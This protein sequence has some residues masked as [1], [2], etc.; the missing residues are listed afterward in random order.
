M[1]IYLT[2]IFAQNSL[3]YGDC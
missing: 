2:V 3:S 1:M